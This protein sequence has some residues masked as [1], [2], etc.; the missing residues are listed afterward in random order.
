VSIV[1]DFGTWLACD[2]FGAPGLPFLDLEFSLHP[3]KAAT[4]DGL[5]SSALL[6]FQHSK[7]RLTAFTQK[8]C[9]TR[10]RMYFR[11]SIRLKR[12]RTLARFPTAHF[13]G[14]FGDAEK[15]GTEDLR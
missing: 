7:R 9:L 15:S 12:F 8:H 14:S 10:G 1:Y 11:W 2:L 3:T 6:L 5:H 13:V 4:L